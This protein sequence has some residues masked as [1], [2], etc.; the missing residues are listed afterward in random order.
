[1]QNDEL[2]KKYII[3]NPIISESKIIGNI[4]VFQNIDNGKI[5]VGKTIQGTKIRW[6]EH[7]RNAFNK[8]VINYFYNA[9]RKYGWEKF[10][11]YVVFQTCELESKKEANKIII[12]KEKFF[13]N[14][15]NSNDSNFGYN[16][17]DGGKGIVGYKH[18][19]ESKKKMSDKRKGE[20]HPNFGNYNNN[21]SFKILQFDLNFNLIKEWPSM[22]QIERE[23]GYKSNNI[24]RCC[25]N[26]IKTY[27]NFIWIKKK[28]F[29][30][31]CF[32]T[33]I[34][35]VD[36]MRT[37]ISK[38]ATNN[39]A[40]LQYNFLGKFIK[41]YSSSSDAA[42]ELKCDSS[43]ISNAANGK[44]I[45]GKNFI[46]IFKKDLSDDLLFNKLEKV[47][48]SKNYSKTI[49]DIKSIRLEEDM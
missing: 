20:L 45:H 25:N 29:K 1:M 35:R 16:L 23:L 47:K 27:K 24:S 18:T 5:Y 36:I 42:R 40:V 48:E 46:W 28:D 30:E 33:K 3:E 9:I 11:K 12:E 10:N 41:K 39:K 32:S 43:L 7:K 19:D 34:E 26:K 17:T 44:F 6:S 8:K 49:E 31:G 14:L 37:S 21:T 15:F 4:Y 13:I 2:L 38:Y 22:A